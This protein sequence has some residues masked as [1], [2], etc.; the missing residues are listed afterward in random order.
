MAVNNIAIEIEG[1]DKVGKDTIA[2]YIGLL[3]N[4]KYTLNVR[5]IL[6]QL[7]YNDKFNRNYE[8]VLPYIPFIIFLDVDNV[9]HAIR[10]KRA[11]EPTININKD[12]E[13]YK[14]YMNELRKHGVTI[15]EYNTSNMTP[16]MIADDIIEK[17]DNTNIENFVC[18]KPIILNNLHIYTADD[19]KGEDVF[20]KFDRREIK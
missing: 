14:A 19:L 18:N 9:D 16:Y 11:H 3:S 1:M 20:Y 12:R 4:Y 8:Y 13:V 6:T 15:L 10:C 5:G 7:V 17:L 2:E